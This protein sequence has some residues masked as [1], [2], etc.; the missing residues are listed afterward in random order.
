[1][2][3]AKGKRLLLRADADS[4]IGD[5]HWMRMLALGQAWIDQGGSATM[6]TRSRS[7][8]H[9]K[10]MLREG[11][12]VFQLAETSLENEMRQLSDLVRPAV[13]D[14]VVL[15]GYHFDTDYQRA[16]HDNAKG[17]MVVDDYRH[18]SHYKADLILNQNIG[19]RPN[20]YRKCAAGA[21]VLAGLE[22]CLLRR[23]FRL[24][25]PQLSFATNPLNW[26]QDTAVHVLITLGGADPENISLTAIAGFE[27]LHDLNLDIRLILGGNNSH[28][29][30]LIDH[31]KMNPRVEVITAVEDMASQYRWADFAV[32]AGGSTNW[33]LCRFEVP[34][35]VIVLAEN[36]QAIADRLEQAGV[37]I[38]LGYGS[39][40]SPQKLADA[41][42][43]LICDRHLR[44]FQSQRCRDLVDG[45]GAIRVVNEILD[46][47]NAR[48]LKHASG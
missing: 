30:S 3:P 16:L 33:E 10:R 1:M 41:A 2:S 46:V 26:E 28:R 35:L 21:K 27:L 20:M 29:D 11:I 9:W 18:L 14:F 22:Y 40:L 39:L 24:P 23:E 38:N 4:Q 43:R 44:Q 47:I 6:A 17:T 32:V 13:A 37:A 42:R 5:G 25:I 34:R 7:D 45:Q 31:L 12:E 19:E 15:D 8:L 48:E 36:Q